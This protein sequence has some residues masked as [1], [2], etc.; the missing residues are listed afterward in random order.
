M[1]RVTLAALH[2]IALGIGLGAI[3]SRARILARQADLAALRR[4]LLADTLWGISAI[5]WI[6]S[7]LWR[8]LG[9]VEKPAGY[10]VHNQ[11]F[12]TKMGFLVLIL[13]LEI[14][15]MITL[16]RWRIG[17]GR[18]VSAE[19]VAQRATARRVSTISHFQ[20]L[21]IVIMVFLA[22]AMA[23]GFGARG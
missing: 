23:R 16:I 20:A 21:L 9:S 12:L 7:G 3:W 15:P 13:A 8:W 2:L 18:G 4:A 14:G 6:G 17:L 5:L 19:L 11:L 1:L 22:A 10:Y